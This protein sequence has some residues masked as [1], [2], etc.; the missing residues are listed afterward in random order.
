VCFVEG[1]GV[2]LETFKILSGEADGG[3]PKDSLPM[4]LFEPHI[5]GSDYLRLHLNPLTI[6]HH[7]E[8]DRTG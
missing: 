7:A 2:L 4:I 6:L 1:Y 5:E 8:P 3:R